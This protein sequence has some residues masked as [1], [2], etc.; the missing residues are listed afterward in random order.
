MAIVPI[1]RLSDQDSEEFGSVPEVGGQCTET[2]VSDLDRYGSD[3]AVAAYSDFCMLMVALSE[4]ES[5]LLETLWYQILYH[6]V[7][8]VE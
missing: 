6:N 4:E 7:L 3:V 5:V 8:P 2:E 1:A